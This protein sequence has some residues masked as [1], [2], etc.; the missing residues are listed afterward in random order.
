MVEP[1][2]VI[3]GASVAPWIYKAGCMLWDWLQKPRS[4]RRKLVLLLPQKALKSTICKRLTSSNPNVRL[5]DLDEVVLARASAE[6]VV[7]LKLAEHHSDDNTSELLR[8]KYVQSAIDEIKGTWLKD[9]KHRAIFVT[10]D[11]NV[12]SSVFKPTSIGVAMPSEHFLHQLIND[13]SP[14]DQAIALKSHAHFKHLFYRP[15]EPISVYDSLQDLANVIIA[16]Y[17]LHYRP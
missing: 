14:E 12:V 15:D 6:D 11:V 7:K 8:H 13:L 2:T 5:Y 3:I 1:N 4:Q 16:H 9:R 17:N 10:S